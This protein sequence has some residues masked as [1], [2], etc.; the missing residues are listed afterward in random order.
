MR[1]EREDAVRHTWMVALTLFAVATAGCQR[2][3]RDQNVN[4]S[5]NVGT[6][7]SP[8]PP[9]P[10]GSAT[11]SVQTW[12]EVWDTGQGD[13]RGGCQGADCARRAN[14][15]G[16][17]AGAGDVPS[18]GK[19]VGQLRDRQQ[20]M[21][22]PVVRH[23]RHPNRTFTMRAVPN[24]SGAQ[25]CTGQTIREEGS[26]AEVYLNCSGTVRSGRSGW[27]QLVSEYEGGAQLCDKRLTPFVEAR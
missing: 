1:Q 14:Y 21:F 24:F 15:L 13:P 8:T 6:P 5:I 22:V 7:T 26:P 9:P 16:Y 23:G 20:V 27:E 18:W 17:I 4:V 2:D 3:E 11:C 19:P 10:A 12:M 25:T